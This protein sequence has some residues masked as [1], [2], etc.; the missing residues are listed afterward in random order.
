MILPDRSVFRVAS[1]ISSQSGAGCRIIV[2]RVPIGVD[3]PASKATLKTRFNL[4]TRIR[5]TE[6]PTLKALRLLKSH[7][8]DL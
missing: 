3:G 2:F 5:Y 4:A 7:E 8:P 6:P 1:S